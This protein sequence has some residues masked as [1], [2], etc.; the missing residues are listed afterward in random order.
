R[1]SP[2]RSF[3]G[4]SSASIPIGEAASPPGSPDPDDA[5][6][7]KEQREVEQEAASIDPQRARGDLSRRPFPRVLHQLFRERATGALFL[8]RDR[9]KKIVFFRDGQTIHVKSN[10]LNECLGKV[11][12]RERMISE[13]ECKESLRIMGQTGRL[14]GTV[15]IEMG[16]ISPQNLVYG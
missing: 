1:T 4:P 16:C 6:Q 10:L 12:V 5:I 7:H 9:I 8:L 11:L 13:D 3:I 15:L 14:Q 2:T